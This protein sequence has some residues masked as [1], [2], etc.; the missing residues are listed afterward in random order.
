MQKIFSTDGESVYADGVLNNGTSTIGI[1]ALTGALC[2]I[3]AF[4][5]DTITVYFQPLVSCDAAL[6]NWSVTG[7]LGALYADRWEYTP[8]AEILKDVVIIAHTASG[9]EAF[10]FPIEIDVLPV[11]IGGSATTLVLGDSLIANAGVSTQIIVKDTADANCA[12][13][14]IGTQD[15]PNRNEGYAGRTVSWFHANADSPF[16]SGGVFNFANYLTVNSFAAPSSVVV[17][18]GT[19]D[20]FSMTSD[21]GVLAA[22]A[23]AATKLESMAGQFVAQNAACKTFLCLV[24]PPKSQDAFAA[25]YGVSQTAWRYKRNTLLWNRYMLSRVWANGILATLTNLIL[26]PSD[27]NNGVHPTNGGYVK[28]ANRLYSVIKYAASKSI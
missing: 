12:I 17:H 13:E 14:L 28:L 8:A 6:Y 4:V 26:A 10:R 24:L 15:A 2:R 3:P 23:D 21:A 5:G 22:A 16:V 1:E 25:D 27:M 20:I 19:N 18:L 9:A 11:T 7:G